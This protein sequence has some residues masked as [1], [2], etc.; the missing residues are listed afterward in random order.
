MNTDSLFANLMAYSATKPTKES[1]R[2]LKPSDK[3][4][5]DLKEYGF[6]LSQLEQVLRTRGNQLILS[7]AGSGKTTALIFKVIFDQ[8][9]GYAS[10]RVVVN[11]N[12]VKVTDS[13]WVC[14][15]L[16][17]GAE[18]LKASLIKWQRRLHTADT[19]SAIQF[20]TLHAEFKRVLNSLG[21]ATDII[22]ESDNMKLLKE[23]VNRYCIMSSDRKPL[24]SEQLRDL[25]GALTYTRN[26]LDSKRYERDTYDE[27]EL[28]PNM[29]DCILRDWKELR[30]QKHLYDFEDLQ[31]KLY[32]ECYV[33]N[34]Q[35]IIDYLSKRYNF[36]YIDEFQD[37]SQIQY[38][39]L[40]IYGGSAKQVVA[41]GDDDQTIYSWRGSYNGII[42]KEFLEDFNPIKNDLNINYRC[43]SN[44]LNAI[45]SSI[46][47]NENRFDK[48]LK[49]YRDG[50][51]VRTGAYANYKQ[52]VSALSDFVS[53]DIAKDRSVA[54]LCRVN[55]DGLMPAL[56][57]DKLT[58]ISFSISGEG[59]TLDS[60]IGRIA[61]NII[62]LFTERATSAVRNALGML[63]WN[64]YCVN[65]LLKVCKNNHLSI[66]TIDVKDLSYSC[67]E[68]AER[69]LVWRRWR[70]QEGDLV[71]LRKVLQDYR[72]NVFSK[73]SH[74][75]DVVKS[76]LFS[77]E[78][79]LDYYNYSYVEDFLTEL[80]DIN[81]RLKARKNKRNVSVRI[82][83]V[84]EFKGKEADSVYVWNDSEGI[85]PYKDTEDVQEELE[86]ERRIHYIAN[87]RAK[88]INTIMY[89]SSKPG[90][91]I[92]EM[93]LSKSE[94]LTSTG[95][96]M[97]KLGNKMKMESNL[98][99]F[100]EKFVMDDDGTEENPFWEGSEEE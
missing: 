45:K 64:S 25:Q 9:T 78:T 73:D 39:L 49:S 85:F 4:L 51:I 15:F 88:Q 38:A 35:D 89:L 32:D 40:K 7:C 86:E 52:M 57:L 82:A 92:S 24:N 99:N 19:S 30:M 43:P 63:T 31:E 1:Q 96:T 22:S 34:N 71:A 59:M 80:E 13:T 29:I 72:V 65:N 48:D 6:E 81:E 58:G 95:S 41:I 21:I 20:S 10:K 68:I 62:K 77:I 27:F 14:T 66:W 60:Y 69:I 23:I 87:T 79:L 75:N 54:I 16:K 8:K 33:K 94:N 74:F 3:M 47:N 53:E 90:M 42:T 12:N 46:S 50:G 37:T 55:S 36:I 28:Y 11:G 83:T 70:E 44:I 26:R 18:E 61:I 5:A 97:M 98:E 2:K 76:V 100:E 17:S 67:P 91:F 56:I 93:D 84:H